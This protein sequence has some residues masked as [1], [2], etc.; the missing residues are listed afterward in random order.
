MIAWFLGKYLKMRGNEDVLKDEVK[1]FDGGGI[2]HLGV[3]NPSS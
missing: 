2:I 1:L 3:D